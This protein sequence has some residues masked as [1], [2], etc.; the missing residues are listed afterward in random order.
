M[1]SKKTKKIKKKKYTR[2][3]HKIIDVPLSKDTSKGSRASIG[4]INYHYQEFNNTFSYFKILL[5]RNKVFR[6]LV[7]IPKVSE[8]WMRAFL[9]QDFVKNDDKYNLLSIRPVDNNVSINEFIHKIRRCLNT[10]RIVPINFTIETPNYGKHANMI[11]FDSKNKTIE[12]F[13]PHGYHEDSQ[14][15]ISRVYIKSISGVKRFALKYF[16]DYRVIS[17]K[18]FESRNGLQA[19]IDAF[20]GMCVTWSILYLNYRI[21]NPNTPIKEL[22]R[23]I[24]KNIKRNKLLRFTRYVELILKKYKQ[25]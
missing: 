12:H 17:P 21:L 15:S 11:I 7:C 18:E 23:H 5:K 22:V 24:N 10:H 8:S 4:E 13:E 2:N 16:P 19:T 14:W 25:I 1:P 20:G 9:I 6:K 3:K